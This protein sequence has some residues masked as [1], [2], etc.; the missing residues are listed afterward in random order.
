M[1]YAIV[2]DIHANFAA[3]RT[4]LADIADIRADQIICLGDMVGYGPQPVEV[5]ESVYRTVQVTLMGNHDAAVC[6]R[7]DPGLF[8]PHARAAV[9]RHRAQL[10][11]AGIAW[12]ERLP[13]VLTAPT[14]RCTHGDFSDPSAFYYILDEQDACPSWRAT[15]EPLLF[16]GHTHMPGIYVSGASGQPHFLEPRDFTLEPGKRYIVNPGSVGYPRTGPFRSSYCLYDDEAGTV[17]FRQL[18]FDDEAYRAALREAGLENSAPW[19]E[20]LILH[21]YRP[22]V[23]ARF[24]F[25]NPVTASQSGRVSARRYGATGRRLARNLALGLL[26]LGAVGVAGRL[27]FRAGHATAESAPVAMMPPFE[28]PV[29]AAYPLMHSGGNLLPPLP[30]SVAPDRRL[31]GWRY[32]LEDRD[33]QR[34]ALGL[35]D[36]GLTLVVRHDG[37]RRFQLESPLI[38]L[39]G[40][41]ITA[42]RLTSR[43]RKPGP[44]EGSATIQLVTYTRLPHDLL[45][46]GRTEQYELRTTRR[47]LVPPGAERNVRIRLGRAVTH[48][49]FR[50]EATFDGVLEIEQPA[51]RAEQEGLLP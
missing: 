22:A 16:A 30:E 15:Q 46:R 1:R 9:L 45:Q 20:R 7:L 39:A 49:R 13:L 47:R 41:R 11:A 33:R 35:R 50:V 37:P 23:R 29:R 2:S 19:L 12:L 21:R 27:I 32:A 25:A 51:L 40:T 17:V 44:F 36:G 42:L 5:L 43:V 34:F 8:L 6:G 48:V 28:L 38:D 14:F 10:S 24:S 4:V 31:D 18:P 3:W 26:A